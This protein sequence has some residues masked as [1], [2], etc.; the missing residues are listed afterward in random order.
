MI[1]KIKKWFSIPAVKITGLFL[2]LILGTT[3]R[4]VF[5][6]SVG[7]FH[8]LMKTSELAVLGLLV[9][10]IVFRFRAFMIFFSIH[11]S[12]WL[13]L[14]AFVVIAGS[15]TLLSDFPINA[16]RFSLRLTMGFVLFVAW[17]TLM[18]FDETVYLVKALVL[19]DVVICSLATLERF[20]FST[21][22]P[23]LSFIRNTSH[24]YYPR[25]SSV[26]NNP[27]VFGSYC[28]VIFAIVFSTFILRRVNRNWFLLGS[29]SEVI[30]IT[31]SGSRNAVVVLAFLL[32]LS[33]WMFRA[34]RKTLAWVIG[35][36]LIVAMGYP[37]TRTRFLVDSAT[38]S[39]A[40]QDRPSIWKAAIKGWEA[41]PW[42]GVGPGNFRLVNARYGGPGGEGVYHAHS[43]FLDFLVS[44]G[45]CGLVW[46]IGCLGYIWS[47]VYGFI[48]RG[49]SVVVSWPFLAAVLSQTFFDYF[50]DHSLPFGIVFWL[51][52]AYSLKLAESSPPTEVNNQ[53]GC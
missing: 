38:V 29:V 47:R 17:S 33:W 52:A 9:F 4:D 49:G 36:F 26:F 28:V 39:R 25:V 10:I 37:S 48:K 13:F 12:L 30:S 16:A 50:L 1:E 41:N 15:S 31:F 5:P 34:E 23:V 2:F 14:I 19:W 21:M 24:S 18:N 45:I 43:L 32:A 3:E 53:T 40:L 42:L 44:L 6:F 27:N 20:A 35:V 22:E 11:R 46:L 7:R 51:T 8:L